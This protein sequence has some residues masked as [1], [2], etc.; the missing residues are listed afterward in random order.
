[1]GEEIK[2]VVGGEWWCFCGGMSCGDCEVWSSG[3]GSDV[4]VGDDGGGC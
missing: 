1:M 3:C 4:G 2:E